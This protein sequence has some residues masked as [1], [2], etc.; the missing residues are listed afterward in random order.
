MDNSRKVSVIGNA[1]YQNDSGVDRYRFSLK[2]FYSGIDLAAYEPYLLINFSDD[3]GDKISLIKAN[4]EDEIV[5]EWPISAMHTRVSGEATCQIQ[6]ENGDSSVV[7][8]SEVFK[9]EIRP[10]VTVDLCSVQAVPTVIEQ[11]QTE[12]REGLEYVKGVIEE[13]L[14]TS[15]NGA[16]GDVAVTP[17]SI[18]AATENFVNGKIASLQNGEITVKKAAD[19][20]RASTAAYADSANNSASAKKAQSA[21]SDGLGNVISDTYLKISDAPAKWEVI[22]DETVYEDT[23][24]YTVKLGGKYNRLF[25]NIVQSGDTVGVRDKGTVNLSITRADGERAVLC[26]PRKA[27]LP[28]TPYE[29]TISYAVEICGRFAKVHRAFSTHYEGNSTSSMEIPENTEEYGAA[30]TVGADIG[31]NYVTDVILA[32]PSAN[33]DYMLFAGSKVTVCGVKIIE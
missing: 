27:F 9:F 13:G 19:C 14:V 26:A 32:F 16:S 1:V 11:L 31:Q 25:I 21:T 5:L 17:S 29:R 6:F 24:E 2:R 18:G 7:Y 10:S 20:D 23:D 22:K 28:N 12:L 15:V 3:T 8:N 30:E 4:S 33:D